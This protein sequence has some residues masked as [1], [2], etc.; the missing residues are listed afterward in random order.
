[1]RNDKI[2]IL[3]VG[4]N[5]AARIQKRIKNLKDIDIPIRCTLL[6]IDNGSFDNSFK[7]IS[8]ITILR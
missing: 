2:G 4:F 1:M 8:D 7:I 6:I 3:L 5:E